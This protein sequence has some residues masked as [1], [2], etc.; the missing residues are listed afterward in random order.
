[1]IK[2]CEYCN[3]EF[4][5]DKEKRFCSRECYSKFCKETNCLKGKNTKEKVL[6]TCAEC[7]KQ[8]YVNSSRAKKYVCCSRG[9]IGKYNSKR[10]N[11]QIEKVCPICGVTFTCKKSKDHHHRTCGKKDCYSA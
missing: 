11:K 6:V 9:C 5:T 2:K 8:E 4:K 1:M 10:Y 7:G 3:K